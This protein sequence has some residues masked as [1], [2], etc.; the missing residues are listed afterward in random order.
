MPKSTPEQRFAKFFNLA[1]DEAAPQTMRDGAEREMAAWLKRHGK[2]KRDIQAILVKAA[3]DDKAQQPPPPPSDPRDD[4]PHPF[5]DPQFTPAGLVEGIVAKYVTM[6]P[7]VS[8]ICSL[9]TCFT[10]VYTQFAIAPR[11][12]L[13]SEDPES[14]KST[15]RKVLKYLVYRPNR[16][17]LGSAAALTRHL[18]R[19]P[20]TM[21]LDELD[22][23]RREAKEKLL[24]IWV[25]GHERGAETSLMEGG[26]E[27]YFNIY[28]PVLGAGIG[29]FLEAG[30]AEKG[31]T[32]T[33][34]MEQYT[35]VNKPPLDYNTDLNTE[36]LNAV[37]S[38]LRNWAQKVKLNPKPPMPAGM[39]RRWA[40]N[41]RGLLSVADS[42]GPEWGRR[43][44]EAVAFLLE[45][46]KAER[47][48]VL[49]LR[50]AL[51]II[52]MLELDP[53]PSLAINRELL[54]LALPE[55]RWNHYRGPGGG[56]YAHALTINEQATLLR[57]SGIESKLFRP[58]GKGRAGK[59]FHGYRRAWFVEALRKRNEPVA[60]PRLRLV[61]P[62]TD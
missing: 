35:E 41:V 25:L 29:K 31:R 10:H 45:K 46:E 28:A 15:T 39:I 58:P 6:T 54:R 2:T 38:Y 55:A 42:C 57:K 34:E 18:A 9:W 47:P 27:K 59:P 14:G 33:L 26:R 1:N 51:V 4:A 20:G 5:D 16:E 7:Y 53:V 37:Y 52:D 40:D 19:G 49:I 43:A 56:E 60:A 24:L 62:E 50:H 36:E 44:R 32:F 61:G 21:L 30:T 13:T 23:V 3:A 11:I 8:V 12:E 48:E 17:V 22:R